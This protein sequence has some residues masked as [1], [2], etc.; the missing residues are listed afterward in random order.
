MTEM[1]DD[2]DFADDITLLS[3]RHRDIQELTND[4]ATTGKHICLNINAGKTKI[5]K[6]NSKSNK[7][8]LLDT[9]RIEEVSNFVYLG[10]KIISDG[11]SEVE[12][13]VFARKLEVPFTRVFVAL[14]N[15]WRSTKI[16]NTTKL[17]ICKSIAL[18]AFY[19][20][21]SSGR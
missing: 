7:P 16:S 15:I 3:H 14:D 5:L 9:I 2:L 13:L 6:V 11:N 4:L 12:V 10:S 8:I 21:L 18:G 17:K 19:M 1:L 20:A